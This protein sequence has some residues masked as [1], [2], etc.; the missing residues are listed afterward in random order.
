VGIE[1][2]DEPSSLTADDLLRVPHERKSEALNEAVDFLEDELR[3]GAKPT[4]EV[5]QRAR[6]LRISDRTLTRARK[7]L[8]IRASKKG[9]SGDWFLS[10]P[11][12][13]DEFTPEDE[14]E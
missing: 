2:L 3:Q 1:W 10:L 14:R 11:T 13:A 8:N 4:E 5:K 6:N 9:F 12:L 7:Q